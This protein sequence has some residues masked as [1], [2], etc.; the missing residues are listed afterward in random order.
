MGNLF[1]NRRGRD[2]R[3][4]GSGRGIIAGTLGFVGLAAQVLLVLAAV[5]IVALVGLYLYLT[6][7][8]REE[9]S[10]A[11]PTLPENS[12]IYDTNG[13]ELG[14]LV[15]AED[16]QTVAPD[17][18]GE[19]L[20]AA[21]MAI[22]D[23]R[24]Y[25]HYGV[26][27][28][29]LARAAYSDVRAGEVVEGG[30]T[31]SEQLV[32]NIFVPAEE[33]NNTSFLRRLNQAML[34][35]AYERQHE[36]DEILTSYLNTVYFGRGVYGAEQASERY[37]DK[38]ADDLTLPESAT[39]AGLLHSP[40]NYDSSEEIQNATDR[41][42]EV[43]Q[44]M[45]EQGMIS[46]G[47]LAQAQGAPLEYARNEPAAGVPAQYDAFMDHV[48]RDVERN[49][50]AETFSNGGLRIQTTIDPERQ[51]AADETAESYTASIPDGP[52]AAITSVEPGTGAV[53]AVSGEESGFNLALDAQRQPGSAFKAFV[54]AAALREDVS[55]ETL[56][57]SEDLELERDGADTYNV[58]NYGGV[59]R[60]VISVDD[61][62]AESDNTVFVQFAMDVGLE[63]MARTA[64]ELGITT[65]VDEIPSAAI[66]GMNR[67]VS[68][69][70]MSSAYA[71]L[72]A[73]GVY[74]EPYSVESVERVNFGETSELYTHEDPGERVMTENQAA[75]ATEVLRGV[76]ERGT[77]AS[78]RSLEAELGLQSAGKTG[79]T[80][81]YADAWYVGYTPGLSTAVWVGYPE[82]RRS[83]ENLAG[84][85]L[86]S[87]ETLPLDIWVAYM[88]QATADETYEEFPEADLSEFEPLTDG[89]AVDSQSA[90]GAG[91]IAGGE[92]PAGPGSGPGLTP[93]IPDIGAEID[94]VFDDVFDENFPGTPSSSP[95]AAP[96]TPDAPDTSPGTAPGAGAPEATPEAAPG[97][98]TSAQPGVAPDGEV[99]A[100]APAQVPA[101]AS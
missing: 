11:R 64:E 56:Y 85:G 34:A 82:G 16:R 61:A 39:L 66:G 67:G 81:E 74:H 72:A 48:R 46:A 37:F 19:Y 13:E 9:L 20:P 76:V 31:L 23:R 86:V 25:D 63:D 8:S 44:L 57:T 51:Q 33:R 50:G 10:A 75:A 24:F 59:E 95:D 5:M 17:Q 98:P 88:T 54:L 93:N 47:E 32:K 89:Y 29:G 41:R 84:Y 49:L 3:N 35:I 1:D 77:A 45:N 90:P 65:P 99:P 97:A 53:R 26:D 94:S 30:S 101:P 78:Y 70:D 92:A 42:D 73:G 62:M 27:V 83:M 68:P 38:P 69:I 36:K 71:T 6:I 12:L 7:T 100:E 14:T 87:G 15:A 22:E 52:S 43:L 60:G 28:N 21:V 2:R 18:M 79:T 96:E 80:E 4:N 55:P 58:E 40:S 91:S